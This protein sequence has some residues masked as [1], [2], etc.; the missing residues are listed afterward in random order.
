MEQVMEALTATEKFDFIIFDTADMAARKCVDYHLHKNGWQH[1]QDGGDYGKGYDI[2]QNTPFRH[3]IGAIMATG[4][5]IGFITHSEIKTTA[6]A[7]GNKSKKETSLPGGIHKFLHTQA[8]IMW[9]GGFGVRQKGNRYRDR[10]VQTEGDE[11]TLAGNRTKN[12]NIPPRF[13]LDPADPW[14]QWCSFFTDPTAADKATSDLLASKSKREKD[15]ED[16]PEGD[17]PEK[18][19]KKKAKAE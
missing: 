12:V 13:I 14:G 9:H 19:E 17:K 18:P 1:A 8:D 11:E 2:V 10:I 15:D 3:M 4:R 16:E 6:F 5:G 7:K